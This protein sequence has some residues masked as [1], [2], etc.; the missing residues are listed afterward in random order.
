MSL[1]PPAR[2]LV[3]GTAAGNRS[4]DSSLRFAPFRMTNPRPWRTRDGG[5]ELHLSAFIGGSISFDRFG[6]VAPRQPLV[7]LPDHPVRVLQ[8]HPPDHLALLGLQV[9]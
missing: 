5:D 9:L 4:R 3:F 6:E 8:T 1:G 2:A 7:A